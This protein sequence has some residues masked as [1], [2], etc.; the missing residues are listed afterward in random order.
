MDT[1]MARPKAQPGKKM[2]KE[3]T[4]TNNPGAQ[5]K[6]LN[7]G[8]KDLNSTHESWLQTTTVSSKLASLDCPAEDKR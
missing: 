4:V 1:Q 2:E 8:Q 6:I 5:I 7:Y 3:E